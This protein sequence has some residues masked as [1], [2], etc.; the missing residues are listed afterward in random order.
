VNFYYQDMDLYY[1][2]QSLVDIVM[3]ITKRHGPIPDKMVSRLGD[4][5]VEVPLKIASISGKFGEHIPEEP[6]LEIRALIF[7]CQALSELLWR[8]KILK[9]KD[10]DE[11]SETLSVIANMVTDLANNVQNV[12]TKRISRKRQDTP[13][14]KP[15]DDN[16]R[17]YHPKNPFLED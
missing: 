11:L 7:Q 8:R 3:R 6:F 4:L 15:K 1:I 9:E 10:A 5:S 12:D 14:P 13:K 2:S 17:I 16:I